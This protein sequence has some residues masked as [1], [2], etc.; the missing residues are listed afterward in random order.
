MKMKISLTLNPIKKKVPLFKVFYYETTERL[1]DI[2]GSKDLENLFEESFI[3]LA[4]NLSDI[5]IIIQIFVIK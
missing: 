5:Q 1:S 3:K 4:D 2:F